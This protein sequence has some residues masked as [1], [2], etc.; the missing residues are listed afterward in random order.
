MNKLK[1]DLHMR[2]R[3]SDEHIRPVTQ[4]DIDNCG[5]VTFLNEFLD[6]C[7][8]ETNNLV[9]KSGKGQYGNHFP[10]LTTEYRDERTTHFEAR[11]N[12]DKHERFEIWWNTK[13]IG[14]QLAMSQPVIHPFRSAPGCEPDDQFLYPDCMNK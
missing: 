5:G 8:D 10:E 3:N 13:T 9:E 6:Y 12:D 7:I 14:R 1:Y 4:E 11:I 2:V